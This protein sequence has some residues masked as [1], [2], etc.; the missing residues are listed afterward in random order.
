MEGANLISLTVNCGDPPSPTDGFL[1]NYSHTREGA[2]VTCQC[3][4]DYRP[5]AAF[6]SLCVA[7]TEWTPAPNEHICTFVTG[8]VTVIIS[9][10]IDYVT[11]IESIVSQCSR[12]IFDSSK[13][14]SWWM[15]WLNKK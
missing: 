7:T 9:Y 13:F 8:T 5:S 14:H 2:T 6:T 1:G 11:R 12:I 3:D 4:I 10:G 15:E